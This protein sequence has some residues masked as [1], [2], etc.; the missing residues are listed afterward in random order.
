MQVRG[1][2]IPG[3]NGGSFEIL[4]VPK[5]PDVRL[6]REKDEEHRL[7]R[8]YFETRIG[9]PH[10]HQDVTFVFPTA[11]CAT[12]FP[13]KVMLDAQSHISRHY[14]QLARDYWR[15]P[16]VVVSNHLASM[17]EWNND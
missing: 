8:E 7:I 15:R 4:D 10:C 14:D 11:D 1:R 3:P 2:H 6:I 17:E 9:C 12:D 13:T 5:P 16:D